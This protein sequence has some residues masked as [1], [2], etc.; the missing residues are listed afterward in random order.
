[1]K[2]NDSPMILHAYPLGFKQVGSCG[3]VDAAEVLADWVLSVSSPAGEAVSF[4]I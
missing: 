3:V 1:M 4:N 2:S